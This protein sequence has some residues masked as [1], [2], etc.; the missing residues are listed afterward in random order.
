MKQGKKLNPF[1]R[2]QLWVVNNKK[3]FKTS[4]NCALFKMKNGGLFSED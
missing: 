4:E 3:A 2:C 1:A